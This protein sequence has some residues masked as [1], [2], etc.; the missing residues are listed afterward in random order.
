MPPRNN[1]NIIKRPVRPIETKFTAKISERRFTPDVFTPEFKRINA[2]KTELLQMFKTLSEDYNERSKFKIDLDDIG[3]DSPYSI[4]KQTVITEAAKLSG[5][6]ANIY[7]NLLVDG[8]PREILFKE[9][10]FEVPE[11][12]RTK[13]KATEE[14]IDFISK[15]GRRLFDQL[16]IDEKN[17][18]AN[19]DILFGFSEEFDD[20]S[21]DLISA[22]NEIWNKENA[23][24]LFSP[25]MTQKEFT[26]LRNLLDAAEI[27]LNPLGETAD[28]ER[29]QLRS[30]LL[31]VSSIYLDAE[32][33]TPK[34]SISIEDYVVD[35]YKFSKNAEGYHSDYGQKNLTTHFARIN[36]SVYDEEELKKKITEQIKKLF[37]D[38]R[39]FEFFDEFEIDWDRYTAIWIDFV[40][41]NANQEKI[42]K[43]KK[44][45]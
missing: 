18:K 28:D 19:L 13:L 21:T 27:K 37:P 34:E 14:R 2:S 6:L 45:G 41:F 8:I 11:F 31:E 24:N 39:D 7:K 20:I 4:V 16:Y 17:L 9:L 32:T 3:S 30:A 44:S 36:G 35:V 33:L 38:A 25:F 5:K 26:T 22:R 42:N 12:I 29:M 1:R 15:E 43:S 10:D 40:T 23:L